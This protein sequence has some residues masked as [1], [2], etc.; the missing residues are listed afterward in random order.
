[1]F[2]ETR[3]PGD[4]STPGN[5]RRIE[6]GTYTLHTQGG[7]RYK[8]WGYSASGATNALPKPG[9]ELRGCAPRTEILIHP[10][11]GFLSSVGC[12]NPCTSLPHGG[13]PITYSISRNRTIAMLEDLKAFLGDDFPQQ[14]ERTVPRAYVVIEGEPAP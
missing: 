9:I 5:N 10:G 12:I 2:A 8:T 11:R 4:N 7:T 6:E 14:N 3:G 1:M 13:E